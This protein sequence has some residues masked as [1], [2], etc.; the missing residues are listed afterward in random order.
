MYQAIATEKVGVPIKG[1]ASSSRVL[2]GA[3]Q[4]TGWRVRSMAFGLYG[5]RRER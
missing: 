4:P 1:R 5:I 3:K 2:H